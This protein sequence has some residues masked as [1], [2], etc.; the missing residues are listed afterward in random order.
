MSE[1][2]VNFQCHISVLIY[3]DKSQCLLYQC[4]KYQCAVLISCLMQRK[5]YFFMET[6]HTYLECHRMVYSQLWNCRFQYSQRA[7]DDKLHP[8][9]WH[10][11]HS[12][13]VNPSSNSSLCLSAPTDTG[14]R[15]STIPRLQLYRHSSNVLQNEIRANENIT[16]MFCDEPRCQPGDRPW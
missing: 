11:R 6:S 5:C 1:I 7:A 12:N 8:C 3:H 2:N 15:L 14:Y 4:D 16:S 10:M 9:V 13:K